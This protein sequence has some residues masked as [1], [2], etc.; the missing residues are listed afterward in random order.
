[1]RPQDHR[2]WIVGPAGVPQTTAAGDSETLAKLLIP[3]GANAA[4]ADLVVQVLNLA[5]E[6]GVGTTG[7]SARGGSRPRPMMSP[8]DP[9]GPD[10]RETDLS[11]TATGSGSVGRS[12]RRLGRSV[13]L[14]SRVS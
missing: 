11:R 7:A 3:I 5:G 12:T 6:R 9:V 10:D 8:A 4:L 13:V 14:A 1:M 2:R